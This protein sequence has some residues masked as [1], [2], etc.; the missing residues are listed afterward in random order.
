M[1]WILFL[2]LLLTSQIGHADS[3]VYQSGAYG[4]DAHVGAV[5]SSANC[6]D[7]S[8][9]SDPSQYIG[10]SFSLSSAATIN[11]I[12]FYKGLFATEP[13]AL[14]VDIPSDITIAFYDS[15]YNVVHSQ[16]FSPADYIQTEVSPAPGASPTYNIHAAFTPFALSAGDYIVYYFG[17]HLGIPVYGD[18]G[19]TVVV[20][21]PSQGIT[22]N[23]PYYAFGSSAVRLSGNFQT[24]VPE[25]ESLGMLL[26]GFG[27]LVFRARHQL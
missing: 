1:K 7:P 13:Q 4:T 24:A 5:C 23:N 11:T 26:A 14:P 27:L 12:D 16:T 17:E 18:Y 10:E 9:S 2:S 20:V 25:P 19:D 15:S 8:Q 21:S 22:F 3:V 6:L